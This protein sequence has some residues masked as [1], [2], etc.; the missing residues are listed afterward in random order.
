MEAI[1]LYG[2][3]IVIPIIILIILLK[4][5]KEI[6][7]EKR[8]INKDIL[9]DFYNILDTNFQYYLL[10]EIIENYNQLNPTSIN[11]IRKDFCN[12]TFKSLSPQFKEELLSVLTLEG[13]TTIMMQRFVVNF[14][15]FEYSTNKN[16]NIQINKIYE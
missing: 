1:I 16:S 14:K 12:R 13:I 10:T 4:K 15:K 7:K 5:P 8:I 3:L 9:N 2:I 6:I 11:K